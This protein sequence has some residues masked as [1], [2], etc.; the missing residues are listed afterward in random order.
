MTAW[1]G[2]VLAVAATAAVW[3]WRWRRIPRWLTAPAALAGLAYHAATGGGVGAAA[4]T[5][6]GLGLGLL[7]V[8]MRAF[9]GGDAKLLAAMGALLGLRLW[10]WSLEF[11]LLAA[12]VVALAQLARRQRL[13]LLGT[14]LGAIVAGWRQN[15]LQPHPQHNLDSP[16]AVTAPFAVALG[17][18]VACAVWL[19]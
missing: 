3:D 8:Q 5:G 6:L 17:I 7:L 18:G 9:G 1:T 13:A 10:F 4:A 19:F 11:G 14:E 16:Q 15:G 2:F 12:A